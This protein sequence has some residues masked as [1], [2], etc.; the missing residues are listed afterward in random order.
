[1]DDVK[2]LYANGDSWT[3]GDIVDPIRFKDQP[4]HVNHPDNDA[5]RLPRVW[6]HMAAKQLG[7]SVLNNSSAG[8]SNDGIIRRTLNDIPKLLKE[9]TPEQI[10]VVIGWTSPERKD[11][12][13][14]T[15]ERG[16]WDILYPAELD[17][18]KDEDPDIDV[19]YKIYT[20][21]Y[22]N[23]EEYITRFI[24][25]NNLLAGYLKS[26]NIKFTFFNAFYEDKSTV[27]DKSEG[28]HNLR[29]SPSLY[30][31]INRYFNRHSQ[32]Q[33]WL[34]N[35][36]LKENVEEFN[37]IFKTN[38]ITTSFK[39]Y[40]VELEKIY[41]TEFL[42][43]HP[44]EIGHNKWATFIADNISKSLGQKQNYFVMDK[45]NQ[46]SLHAP[47]PE[48]LE[49]YKDIPEINEEDARGEKICRPLFSQSDLPHVL[50]FTKISPDNIIP[51]T[52]FYY[53]VTLHHHN[54]LA[55]KHL[56][57]LP[58]YV[59]SALR[60]N[61]CRLI[62]DNSLEGDKAEEFYESLYKSLH[63]LDIN[64]NYIT[65]VTSNLI[66]EETHTKWLADK[67]YKDKKINVVSFPW[68]I[69]DVKRLISLGHLPEEVNIDKEIEYKKENINKIKS[70]LKVN[71]TC[72][73]ERNIF[74][75]FINRL[76]LYNRFKI[77]FN[78]YNKDYDLFDWF[79]DLTGQDNIDSLIA[80]IPFDIDETD[81]D[82]HGPPGIG[83]GKFD[84]DLP[85]NPVHY[86]N[87]LIST[88]MCAFPFVENA[89]H[90]HSSTYNP[91]YCGHPVIQ[92]GPV[93]HLK[94]LKELG[95]K[96][97]SKWWDESYD[98]EE[99]GWGRLTKILLIVEELCR[100]SNEELLEMYIDMKDTLQHNSDLI[101]NY[102]SINILTKRITGE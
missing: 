54:W 4:W 78:N 39:N 37:S 3:A 36:D 23:E 71:R 2:I 10:Y 80:K 48:L 44:T 86:K 30:G 24:N 29:N 97:F 15:K 99:F 46:A 62:L 51:D 21:K 47:D 93:R 60:N 5:Y 101:K 64:P 85:F 41:N 19:F 63:S 69:Y 40:I 73:P 96:T 68:N 79:P 52:K 102:D 33:S 59:L 67:S 81:K 49:I 87:T 65:Y 94:K 70:F 98:E 95:F 53:F 11:F 35:I 9:Y 89:C 45:F 7:I 26:K 82:N 28:I 56:N 22:W 77:S 50:D 34:N 14:K 17:H 31:F 66:A 55:A 100:K 13:Y 76:N 72:R 43:Y 1:M 90:I 91:I 32:N 83:V 25:Q 92:F 12:F 6:P 18:Y 27:L 58:D 88:V 8:S 75:L 61:N 84:A 38:Y 16:S 57:L 42:D 20:T 74:M